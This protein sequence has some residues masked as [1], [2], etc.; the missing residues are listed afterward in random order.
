M[1]QY[2]VVVFEL[3]FNFPKKLKPYGRGLDGLHQ[4]HWS[5]SHHFA[6]KIKKSEKVTNVIDEGHRGGSKKLIVWVRLHCL[7]YFFVKTED[8]LNLFS[9]GLC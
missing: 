9:S 3:R 5:L 7:V 1:C 8:V 6:C 4:L 2:R